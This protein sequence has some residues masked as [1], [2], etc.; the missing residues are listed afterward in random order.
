[1]PKTLLKRSPLSLISQEFLEISL[2]ASTES[3]H[4]AG[5][6]EV[7]REESPVADKPRRW[8]VILQVNLN[9]TEGVP[10]PPY[11]GQVVIRGVYEVSEGYKDDPARLIRVTGASMLY[12]AVREMV[13]GFTARSAN[14]MVTLPSV[15]FYEKPPVAPAAKPAAKKAVK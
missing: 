3:E 6:L 9:A 13:T 10:P 5:N 12:G 11:I 1:M 4:G 2:K 14:G 7:H 15:S 8:Q